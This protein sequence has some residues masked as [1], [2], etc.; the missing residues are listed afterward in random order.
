MSIQVIP[1]GARVVSYQASGGETQWPI[2]WPFYAAADVQVLRT[3]G[4]TTTTLTQPADYTVQGAGNQAGGQVTLAVP[5]AAGQR[6]TVVSVQPFGRTSAYQDGQALQAA[7]LNADVNRLW[8]ALQQLRERVDRAVRVPMTDGPLATQLPPAGERANRVLGFDGAGQPVAI[9]PNPGNLAISPFGESLISSANPA[10]ARTLL[11]APS[12]A[13]LSSLQSSAVLR[14]GAQAMTGRLLLAQGAAHGFGIDGDPTTGIVSDAAGNLRLRSGGA[15][16]LSIVGG[17]ME[18]HVPLTVPAATAADHAMRWGQREA[19]VFHI[20]TI[21]TPVNAVIVPLPPVPYAVAVEWHE[22]RIDPVVAAAA[23]RFFGCD[24]STDNQANWVIHGWSRMY[25]NFFNNA[26][27][28][29]WNTSEVAWAL[30]Y[31]TTY[32]GNHECSGTLWLSR[33]G[34]HARPNHGH[35]VSVATFDANANTIGGHGIV[36]PNPVPHP[37]EPPITHLRFRWRGNLNMVSGVVRVLAKRLS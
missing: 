26:G 10:A 21:T 32:A 29:G 2:P 30:S 1:D 15:D 13:D 33:I 8:V 6:Y 3:V 36:G 35:F 28:S 7:S 14:S 34:T 31:I 4:S 12:Q 16:R 23:G 5:A 24:Y 9:T 18:A 20:A 17:T 19:Q 22:M 27:A 11:Q 25:G 37:N